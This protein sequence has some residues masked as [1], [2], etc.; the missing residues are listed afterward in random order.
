MIPA[1][2]LGSFSAERAAEQESRTD[3]V[4]AMALPKHPFVYTSSALG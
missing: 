4:A 2:S 3:K 1:V